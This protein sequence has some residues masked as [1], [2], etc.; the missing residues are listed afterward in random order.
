MIQD[1]RQLSNIELA[2]EPDQKAEWENNDM[3]RSLPGAE[4]E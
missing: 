3:W 2:E 1:T 4:V